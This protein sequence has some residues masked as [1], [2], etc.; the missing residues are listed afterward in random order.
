MKQNCSRI[1]A[2][3]LYRPRSWTLAKSLAKELNG[4]WTQ[5][6]AAAML[7]VN[8]KQH[9]PNEELFGNLTKITDTKASKVW[10]PLLEK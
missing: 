6:L 2:V 4:I 3:P 10:W 7:N 9:I 5:L 8:S 1:K